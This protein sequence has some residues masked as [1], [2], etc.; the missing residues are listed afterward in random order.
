MDTIKTKLNR[1]NYKVLMP[2]TNSSTI[3]VQKRDGRLEPL[4]I[5]KI[6]FVV[7]EACEGLSGVSSS[8]IEMNANIQFY[9]GMS[10]KDIQNVLVRSANDLISLEAPNY[11]FAAAR[12]LSYDVRKEAHG[13]YEYIPLL[14]LILRNIRL[15]VY[16]KGIL[17]KYNKTEIKKLNTWIRRDRDLKFTYAGLRQICDKY[18]VQDR[19][20]GQ[21]YETPQ[22]MYMM[23]AATLF[24]EYPEKTRMQYVKRYY[25]AISLHKINIPTPVMAGV[26]TPIRQFASCV[27]VDS[28]DTLPS[29]FSSD[30]AIGL[31]VARR[32]GI[33]INAGRIRGINSKIRGGEV[34]HTGVIPF[35]KKFESTVRCCTQNGV[36][37]GNAT[38]H[39]PIWHP[40]IEDIL[41]LKNNKGT[42]DNRVR[43]MDY[44]IQISKLFY[45]RF[46]NE[47]DITL[48]SPHMAP[49]LYEAFGTEDFDD[50]YLKYEA[51]K[52][53]PKKTV[54]AQDLF[55]DL[56]KERAETGRI[57]IMNLD[58]CNSHSSFKDKVSM[59]NLCQEITLPTTPIQDIHDEQGEIALC[60]LSAIN[61]GQL[62]ELSELENLCDLS[63]RA[64][65]QIIDYQDYPVKAAEVS[66]KKR[67]SLGIGYIGLAHY[68]AKNGV[69]YNEKSAWELVDRLSEAFQYYLLR[70]SCNIAMEKG[71]C[72]GFERT[73]YADGLLPIDHYKKE[74]DEIVPHKQRMAWESLRKDIAKHG[75]RHST[76][77]AQMPSE[78]SSVVSNETNGIEPPRAMLQIKKSKKGP[79]KQIAPGFPKLKNDYTLLWD[80]P[81]N[82]GYINVVAMMQKYFD[83]AISGNWSYNPLHYENN[84]V[85]L[86]AMAQD[87]LTAYKYGWKTS[88]YQNTYDFK[89][90]EEDVQP[91]GIGSIADDEGEDVELPE[92]LQSSNDVLEGDD[93]DAC[94]I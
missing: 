19:S 57:Y 51:D 69:K 40:E 84:E 74:I 56:L 42:E 81:D 22:D 16:D 66:T 92:E 68:L 41:V 24:A 70:A 44:S 63:V 33:G 83:Q 64:L 80:M 21:L 72:E 79:L 26:R 17:D 53:I 34:Q 43:R 2:N 71:K 11:Q 7:E 93:C 20:T 91:A 49:G 13:Q 36:R 61:V 14:K 4:D 25:D 75:L 89:G 27:L 18:L 29:I 9:D 62:G 78:S 50:L 28:D 39:F 23:I 86:S 1:K 8:Q 59:S 90:E 58:H 65:E 10:T 31:Y 73:K 77:S 35:L 47:E 67:R 76:L 87:M 30:M 85:P 54:P 46:M 94:T 60:I 37:G 55:F 32:A 38:V 88:Y 6:H 82:T 48:I 3:Q 45:E 15:G 12:L 5:N 52:T